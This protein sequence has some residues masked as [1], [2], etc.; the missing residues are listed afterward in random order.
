M[1]F[2]EM[3]FSFEGHRD[4]FICFN[5]FRQPVIIMNPPSVRFL[6]PE[7]ADYPDAMHHYDSLLGLQLKV[8]HALNHQRFA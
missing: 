5:S 1:S 7:S 2:P 6:R 3:R 8:N 4:Y